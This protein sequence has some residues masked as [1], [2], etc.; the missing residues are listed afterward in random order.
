MVPRGRNLTSALGGEQPNSPP[1]L[2]SSGVNPSPS[3]LSSDARRMPCEIA[4]ARNVIISRIDAVRSVI[5]LSDGSVWSVAKIHQKKAA[6]WKKG[7][8]LSITKYEGVM[9]LTKTKNKQFAFATQMNGPRK[10]AGNQDALVAPPNRPVVGVGGRIYPA[11]G[12][13]HW[14]KKK[15]DGGK[16]IILE[17][18]SVWEIDPFDRIST[19]LWLVI[20]DITV[21]E[22]DDGTP[23]YD[24]LLI[25]TDDKEKAHA[26]YL[27]K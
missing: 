26:K 22:S 15:A 10:A 3:P 23:G 11:T 16:T 27:G 19:V 9:I 1:T 4:A 24:Y 12:K 2:A 8:K 18:G 20:D 21:V 14:I 5:E 17:D 13:G 6:R 7:D 25:N